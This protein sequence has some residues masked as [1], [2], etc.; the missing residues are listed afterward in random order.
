MK[1][2]N[3]V[4]ADDELLFRQGIKALLSKHNNLSVL[5]D[6]S[7]GEELIQFLSSTEELPEILLMDLKMPIMNGVEA[8]KVIKQK[9]PEIKIIALTSYFSKP[10]IVNMISLGA[11]AYLA[12][13][14]SPALMLKTISEVSEKGFFYDQKVMTYIHEGLLNPKEKKVK[15]KFDATYFTERELEVLQLITQQYTT[16]E[17]GDQLFIS[18]RTV[19][20][21]RNNLML[22]TGVKNMAGLVIYGLKNKLV[23]IDSIDFDF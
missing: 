9:F 16:H 12:K 15:S 19:E 13:N 5:F 18:P 17:I 2:I 3:L 14:S 6:V 7:N 21:H 8:T 22:K 23:T 20:G 4:L 10:F 1:K 11:V